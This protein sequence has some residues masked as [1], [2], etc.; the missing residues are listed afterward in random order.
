LAEDRKHYLK[1]VE[2]NNP[3]IAVILKRATTALQ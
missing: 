1:L 2:A 3:R